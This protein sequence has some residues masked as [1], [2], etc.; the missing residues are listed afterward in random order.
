MAC[1]DG[2]VGQVVGS[3]TS[4][5]TGSAARA[6][7]ASHPVGVLYAAAAARQP[8]RLAPPSTLPQDVPLVAGRIE[9]TTCHDGRSTNPYRVVRTAG[10]CTACHTL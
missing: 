4:S 7:A 6:P 5:G 9:C 1:H 10:L 2:G 8:G 3:L